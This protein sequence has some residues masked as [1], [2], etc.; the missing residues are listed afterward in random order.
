MCKPS[1]RNTNRAVHTSVRSF[2]LHQYGSVFQPGASA[3]KPRQGHLRADWQDASRGKCDS[4]RVGR[5]LRG[6]LLSDRT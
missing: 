1:D 3:E 5:S 6:R 4:E 2:F